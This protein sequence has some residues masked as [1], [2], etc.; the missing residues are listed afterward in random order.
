MNILVTGERGYLCRSIINELP[1]NNII[2]YE[3]DVRLN[4]VFS[5]IDMIIHFASPSERCE[6]K[7]IKKTTTTIIDGTINMIRIAN[8]N[9]AKLVFAST[10][11]V[12]TFGVDDVYCSCKRAMEHYII[13]NCDNYLITRIPRVYSSCRKKGLIKSLIDN[14][15]NETDFDVCVDYLDLKD[16]KRQFLN[17]LHLKNTIYEFTEIKTNTIREIKKIYVQ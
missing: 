16:F 7:D 15:V 3:R 17:S 4:K 9:K 1:S 14:T 2:K 5:N 10:M 13:A 12:H 11:G 8:T 6:F